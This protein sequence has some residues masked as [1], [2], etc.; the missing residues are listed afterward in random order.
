[1]RKE[2]FGELVSLAQAL[3]IMDSFITP[4]LDEEVEL[5][6]SLF[7]VLAADII[8]PISVPHFRKSAMDGFAVIASDTFGANDT[9]PKRLT[10]IDTIRAGMVSKKSITHSH[11]TEIT[12]GAPIP[13]GADAVIMVEC[14]E[15]K[16][17]NPKSQIQMLEDGKQRTEQKEKELI[18]YKSVAPG[19]NVIEIGSDIKCG[20]LVFS[21]GTLLNSRYT[22]VLAAMGISSIRVKNKPIVG[23]L[24]T[25]NEIIASGNPLVDGKIYDINSRTLIDAL[26]EQNCEP[27]NLGL[28]KDNK[29][30]LKNKI[31]DSINTCD[32][33]L[34]SG[35]SSLGTEDLMKEIISEI[36]E[37]LV[38][39][40]AVKPGKPTIIAKILGKPVIGLPGHPTSALSDFYIL[41]LP[42]I[43]KM[44][45]INP[46]EVQPQVEIIEAELNR[47]VVSTIG[48]Y[49]FLAVKID[50]VQGKK[51][52]APVLRGS[53]AITTLATADGFIEISENTEVLTKGEIVKVKLF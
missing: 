8:S 16:I 7:R 18:I 46:Q 36:G 48:R 28:V 44:L 3:K 33:L 2:G 52:A 23:V 29:A 45:G 27:I 39:G 4:L 10:I 19:D 34:I 49:E 12:T 25:G 15:D 37:L 40:I 26:I 50:V 1:M 38:H 32:L 51:Y 43:K 21:K 20:T 13:E 6:N 11:C 22:G 35:G 9:H 47:K 31:L 53:S 42:V 14:T 24:S 41:V 17:Q 5:G 30:E